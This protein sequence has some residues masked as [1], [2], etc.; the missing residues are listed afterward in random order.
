MSQTQH[1]IKDNKFIQLT[2]KVFK[3]NSSCS[4]IHFNTWHS[5]VMF[6]ISQV[7]KKQSCWF[8]VFFL[9]NYEFPGR[10][11]NSGFRSHEKFR[12]VQ[13]LLKVS[14]Y[15]LYITTIVTH[16]IKCHETRPPPLYYLCWNRLVAITTEIK[17]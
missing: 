10:T 9:I 6:E 14:G 16:Y 11:N 1:R 4:S 2:G 17:L 8:F 12:K 5:L 15:N 3:I 7:I 13:P